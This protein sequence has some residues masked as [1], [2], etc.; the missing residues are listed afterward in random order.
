MIVHDTQCG[1]GS[2][3]KQCDQVHGSAAANCGAS[4]CEA[5]NCEAT[6]NRLC[7]SRNSHESRGGTGERH[8]A[9]LDNPAAGSGAGRFARAKSAGRS[10]GLGSYLASRIQALATLRNLLGT[11][12]P[13]NRQTEP[14]S[15]PPAAGDEREHLS[16][17]G[18]A[19]GTV[20]A[21][22]PAATATNTKR[23]VP[24]AGR[25]WR[26]R[27]GSKASSS[28]PRKRPT[29]GTGRFDRLEQRRMCAWVGEEVI[30]AEGIQAN[31]GTSGVGG[32]SGSPPVAYEG[33]VQAGGSWSQNP[34]WPLRV[35]E[36]G[37][38]N[39]ATVVAQL[40]TPPFSQWK[41]GA[42]S[43]GASIGGLPNPGSLLQGTPKPG[44]P[45]GQGG[46]VSQH[47]SGQEIANMAD[48]LL[49]Q[50]Q[51]QPS[52]GP[53]PPSPT[54]GYKPGGPG[55]VQA[56]GQGAMPP[57]G[58]PSTVAATATTTATGT[59]KPSPF[60][61]NGVCTALPAFAAPDTYHTTKQLKATPTQIPDFLQFNDGDNQGVIIGKEVDQLSRVTKKRAF[62]EHND[63]PTPTKDDGWLFNESHLVWV[64]IT[65]ARAYTEYTRI[66]GM[67]HSNNST[68][69]SKMSLNVS[70]TG[71]SSWT[72][73]AT[74]GFSLGK[75]LSAKFSEVGAT[76]SQ[77]LN[78]DVSVSKSVTESITF[79]VDNS[80]TIAPCDV[81]TLYE[82]YQIVEVQVDYIYL[83]DAVFGDIKGFDVKRGTE[84]LTSR[85]Y[86]GVHG[87]TASEWN[88]KTPS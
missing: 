16:S 4:N 82:S 30:D 68:E 75:E 54:V 48:Q 8:T 63:T 71:T 64:E 69:P 83:E 36:T 59:T 43:S 56:A 25:D 80:F 20:A 53:M 79:T 86:A 3:N 5:T 72:H 29:S 70:R 28:S 31:P 37:F 14:G 81:L 51:P 74:S 65:A 55:A 57:G 62:D 42:Q 77:G 85:I 67:T 61:V 23:P 22:T 34:P 6:T 2:R 24:P 46:V 76:V 18:Q 84:T 73:G 10:T 39:G 15:Q 7:G 35:G 88:G 33:P 17:G 11:Q 52:V 87:L 21:G 26:R 49:N 47:F 38:P 12:S 19:T 9:S 66:P 60:L 32:P 27:P 45:A 78:L 40:G 44:Q 1:Q 58:A 50:A 41:P 13:P